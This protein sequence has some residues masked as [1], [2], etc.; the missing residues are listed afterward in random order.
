MVCFIRV[1]NLLSD[2]LC[3]LEKLVR[4][5]WTTLLLSVALHVGKKLYPNM[6][7]IAKNY[8]G[9]H[10]PHSQ[11]PLH[12]FFNLHPALSNLVQLSK[13]MFQVHFL[14]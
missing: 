4:T 11:K 8:A 2:S 7:L 3:G 6:L 14:K 9:I 12:S 5:G 1:N 13:V 10:L